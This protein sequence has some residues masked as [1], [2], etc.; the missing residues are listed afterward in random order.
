MRVTFR[1]KDTALWTLAEVPIHVKLR[2]FLEWILKELTA[3]GYEEV[4]WSSFFRIKTPGESGVHNTKPCRAADFFVVG[5]STRPAER[6][7]EY[8]N[9]RWEHGGIS[10]VTGEPFKVLIW[11]DTGRGFHF[12][13][14]VRDETRML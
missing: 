5:M 14:Q 12:H 13:A 2:F 8:V 11:H 9:N 7:A 1:T 3:Q 4:F 10:R 6:F